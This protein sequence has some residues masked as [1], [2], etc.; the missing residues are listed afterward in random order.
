MAAREI[1]GFSNELRFNPVPH[2]IKLSISPITDAE[3]RIIPYA[4]RIDVHGTIKHK[5][6]E[7]NTDSIELFNTLR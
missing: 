3:N 6:T 1:D 7:L 5:Y 2:D 4:F